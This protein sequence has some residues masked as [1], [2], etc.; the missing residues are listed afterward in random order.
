MEA[1]YSELSEDYDVK[2]RQLV[3]GYDQMVGCVVDAVG[4]NGP[5]AVL[6]IGMGTGTLAQRVVETLGRTALT[7][8]E[9][10]VDMLAVAEGRLASE[11]RI[12][13]V[14]ANIL[15]YEPKDP[16]AAIYTNLVLHNIPYVEKSMLLQRIR[17]WLTPGG[18]FVW[19]DLIR[20]EDKVTQ[21]K[22]VRVRIEH[23]RATGCPEGLVERNFLKEGTSDFPL[24]ASA[25]IEAGLAAGFSSVRE[26]WT[27]DTFSVFALE[28]QIED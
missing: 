10:S 13:V 8:V 27:R 2:I 19:G 21:E 4:S 28:T 22:W 14:R 9:T 24:A 1:Y 11:P 3:P 12:R 26:I 20:H 16:F 6:D 5:S 7:G 25:T 17:S 15:E 18:L 23:A